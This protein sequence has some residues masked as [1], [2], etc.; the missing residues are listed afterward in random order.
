MRSKPEIMMLPLGR[1]P[2]LKINKERRH[3]D[4]LMK[5]LIGDLDCSEEFRVVPVALKKAKRIWTG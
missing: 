2:E 3:R 4:G 1:S 5:A